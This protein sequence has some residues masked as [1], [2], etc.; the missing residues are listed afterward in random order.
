MIY[1]IYWSILSFLLLDFLYIILC[2]YFYLSI[3]INII[4]SS[5]YLI[6]IIINLKKLK[7]VEMYIEIYFIMLKSVIYI[8]FIEIINK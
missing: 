1:N 5:Q 2:I 6:L 4:L 7:I 3:K 8:S